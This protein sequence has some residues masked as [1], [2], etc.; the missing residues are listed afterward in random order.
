L[1]EVYKFAY[2]YLVTNHEFLLFLDAS[3]EHY[4]VWPDTQ[5]LYA[6]LRLNTPEGQVR[7]DQQARALIVRM[8]K[9]GLIRKFPCSGGVKGCGKPHLGLT[10]LGEAQ[11]ETWNEMGCD[12]HTHV[13]NCHA[14]DLEVE[15]D[16]E[17]V[18]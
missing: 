9:K 1:I 3:R 10:K 5:T 17:K 8:L 18:G 15:F 12:A 14:P 13:G 11:L 4:G 16:K 6:D 2:V 7:W